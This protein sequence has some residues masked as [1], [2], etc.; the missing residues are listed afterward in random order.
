MFVAYYRGVGHGAMSGRTEYVVLFEDKPTKRDTNGQT[1]PGFK[2]ISVTDA[3]I[4]EGPLELPYREVL[5][6]IP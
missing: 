6:R 1:C 5:A 3:S 2:L 4:D